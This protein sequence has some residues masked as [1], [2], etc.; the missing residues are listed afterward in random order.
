M[1]PPAF[2]VYLNPPLHTFPSNVGTGGVNP[3]HGKR[4]QEGLYIKQCGTCS[5]PA[6]KQC[7]GNPQKCIPLGGELLLGTINSLQVKNLEMY[8]T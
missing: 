1:D 2:R 4:C 7:L 5:A 3:G 6:L 8:E